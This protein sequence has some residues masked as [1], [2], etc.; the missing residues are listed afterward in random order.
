MC[1]F[2]FIKNYVS[3]VISKQ[4]LD[5]TSRCI[6]EYF[7]MLNAQAALPCMSS[8]ILQSTFVPTDVF[9][10]K[11]DNRNLGKGHYSSEGWILWMWAPVAPRH[12]FLTQ[13]PNSGLWVETKAPLQSSPRALQSP[14]A[15]EPIK[16]QRTHCSLRAVENSFPLMLLQTSPSAQHSF[17]L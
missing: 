9:D 5:K 1:L 4:Y 6:P 10:S 12:P 11:S 8:Q 14:A 3:V 16:Q 7:C 2:Y 13:T 15:A 17:Q